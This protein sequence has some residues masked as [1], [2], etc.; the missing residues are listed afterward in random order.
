MHFPRLGRHSKLIEITAGIVLAVALYALIGFQLIPRLLSSHAKGFVAEHYQRTL[1]LDA[2]RFDPFALRLE[3]D[4]LSL[5]DRDGTPMLAVQHVA[6]DFEAGRSLW[7]WAYVLRHIALVTPQLH[8]VLR[9]DGHL[10]FEDLRL[11]PGDDAAQSGL[12]PALWVE[13][14]EVR[15]GALVYTDH[16]RSPV[17]EEELAPLSFD[18]RHFRTT[19]E[20]GAFALSA[21]TLEGAKLWWKGQFALAPRLS[22]SGHITVTGFPLRLV[23]NYLGER[24]PIELSSGTLGLTAHYTIAFADKL[25][26]TLDVPKLS[27]QQVALAG[28]SHPQDHIAIASLQVV[29]VHAYL[30]ESRLEVGHVRIDGVETHAVREHD[31]SLNLQRMFSTRKAPQPAPAHSLG[32]ASLASSWRVHLGVLDLA[33]KSISLEDRTLSPPHK[34]KLAQLAFHIEDLTLDPSRPLPVSLSLTLDGRTQLK[35]GGTFT[36]APMAAELHLDLQNLA[37]ASLHGYT[38]PYA[39]LNIQEGTLSLTGTLKLAAQS[40]GGLPVGFAGDLRV[41]DFQSVDSDLGQPLLSW[42]ELAL[43]GIHVQTAPLALRV[44]KVRW[45]QPFARVVLSQ[46]Q[47]LNLSSIVPPAETTPALDGRRGPPADIQVRSVVID[48]MRLNFTD[49]FIRPNFSA[50]AH[51]LRGSFSDLS[52]RTDTRASLDLRG[53]LG[54]SAPVRITSK[55]HPFDYTRATDVTL[56]WSNVPLAVFNP[57]SGRFAGY[58]ID[59]GDLASTLQYKVRNGNLAAQHHIRLDQLTWGDATDTKES[60]TLPVRLATALLRD[61]HGVITLDVP[62]QGRLSDPTFRVGPLVWQVVKNIMVRAVTAPFDWVGS[63]FAGAEKARFVD[64]AP[65]ESD[66]SPAARTQL[67]ALAAALAERPSIKVDVPLGVVA[68]RDRSALIDTKYKALIRAGIHAELSEKYRETAF[69]DLELDDQ[70]EVL[71]AIYMQLTGKPPKL[72]DA[73]E[74]QA[75]KSFRERRA[76]RRAFAVK[77]LDQ[78]TRAQVRVDDAALDRLGLSRADAIELALKAE[79]KIDDTRVL[80]SS[81]GKVTDEQGKIRFELALH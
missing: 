49:Y 21:V 9:S 67:A 38:H 10:N 20:G 12:P 61:R 6:V 65:G 76:L 37:L 13:S 31:G 42:Q 24:S 41:R 2:V 66:L 16:G 30:Q 7:E 44:D 56:A 58:K 43:T 19:A 36:P 4:G 60:A 17:F 64:F 23:T 68:E 11:P 46:K 14:L 74:P 71:E 57:Y 79:G 35:A 34:A 73:P 28:R 45:H 70:E 22:S 3:L 50:E 81:Q 75:G 33:G 25:T 78:L 15:T 8:P 51:D 26:F 39:N 55:L 48:K 77:T 72:P 47:V 32:T 1:R 69:A 40:E 59:R 18:L 27:L 29:D 5:P 80:V 53:T 52:T 63:K 54:A 62:V